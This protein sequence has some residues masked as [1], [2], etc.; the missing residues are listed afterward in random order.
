[1]TV[2]V[3]TAGHIDHGKTTLLRALTGIDADRLPEERRRGMT[4][5]VGYAHLD[6]DDGAAIDFVDVPGHDALIGNMLVG[7]G[8]IDA[9]LLVVAGDDGPNAQT[10]E[11]MELLDALGIRDAVAVVTKLDVAGPERAAEVAGEV[12]ALLGW[13]SMTGAVVVVASPMTGA[14]M[15]D[16]RREVLRLH[17]RCLVRAETEPAG[18]TRLAIDRA[19]LVKGR[20]AV[21]TGSLRGAGLRAGAPLRLEPGGIE[22]RAR[23][24]QVHGRA[25]DAAEP[26]RTAINVGGAELADLGRGSVLTT[27]PGVEVGDRMLVALSHP[28]VLR[29]AGGKGRPAWP[30]ADG[31]RARLHLGTAQVDVVVGRRGRE[32]VLLPDGSVTAVLRLARSIATAIG[33]RAVIRRPSPGDVI[34]GVRVL[35]PNPPRGISRRRADPERLAELHRSVEEGDVDAS[36]DALVGLHGVIDATRIAAVAGALATADAL[37]GT[38]GS[39]A[40]DTG[41]APSGLV[42]AIDV[43]EQLE[44]AAIDT[45]AAHH[46]DHPLDAGAPLAAVRRD[47]QARLRRTVAVPRASAGPAESAIDSIMAELV[48]R[49]RLERDGDRLRDPAVAAGPTTAL[50]AAMDRLAALLDVPSPPDLAD[51]ARIAGCPPDGVRALEASGRIVR[52]ESNL[53]WSAAAFQRLAAQALRIARQ[54]PLTPAA[55]RD[56]T[57]SSR[58]YV[59]PL[60]EDLDRRGILVRTPAGHLP[61]PRAPRASGESS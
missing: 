37:T 26:G 16:V 5:D 1:M 47:L 21:V 43:R 28:T 45:V 11:H 22:V 8:E 55:L 19:F 38:A 40:R 2:V 15:A 12:R 41:P 60:L 35:D 57:G 7:A 23:G 46:R 42:L 27:G 33:D 44:Q 6:L 50:A 56:A 3:G 29:P 10:F 13:T 24:L 20:G 39:A 59:M 18:P 54:G 31:T 52:V 61:G 17:E 25:V 36:A 4:I 32:I 51:A 30:P 53:A 9:A 48:S 34:G 49:H 58:R 14:G